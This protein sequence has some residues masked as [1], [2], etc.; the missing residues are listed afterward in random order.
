VLL[1]GALYV[2]LLAT[3]VGPLDSV[4]SIDQ[5]VRLEHIESLLATRF[6][7][8][9]TVYPGDPI[10]P[11]HDF[12]PLLNQY[13]YRDGRSYSMFSAAFSAL[14]SLPYRFFSYAGLYVVPIASTLGLLLIAG[15]L[16]RGL[17]PPRWR[18]VLI[19]ALSLTTPL[20]FYSLVFWDHTL[21]SML[22][23]LAL[24]WTIRADGGSR[25]GRLAGAGAVLGVAAWFRPEMVL[26]APSLA[27]ALLLA[28]VPPGWKL[29]VPLA[30]GAGAGLAPLFIFNQAA[31]GTFLGPHVLVAARVTYPSRSLSELLRARAD[32]AAFLISPPWRVGIAVIGVLLVLRFLGARVSVGAARRS[33]LLFSAAL[34]TGL[35]VIL[36][37]RSA[38]GLETTL[39]VTAPLTLLWLLPSSP[40]PPPASVDI[41]PGAEPAPSAEHVERILGVFGISYLALAFL[42]GLPNGGNQW[43]P[44]VLLPAVAP[45]VIAGFLRAAAWRLQRPP[46]VAGAAVGAAFLTLAAAGVASEL[47][48]LRT[49]EAKNAEIRQFSI[50]VA[51]TG[52]RVVVCSDT[53][54]PKLL[55]PIF[56]RGYLMFRAETPDR[57]ARFVPNLQ[58]NG[59]RRFV[60]IDRPEQPVLASWFASRGVVA[61]GPPVPLPKGYQLTVVRLPSPAVAPPAAD[62]PRL[63]DEGV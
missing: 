17:L 10:D 45:L 32:W 34:M 25:I 56:Y 13:L 42:A 61:E 44:R 40:E 15:R 27:L 62:S 5:G 16:T 43:G 55:A 54:V 28:K 47:R 6:H 37:S 35:G 24:H 11:K 31:Y 52:E 12:T 49:L 3:R 2:V 59:F 1:V 26:A 63:A 38:D 19:L 21:V 14:T 46:G 4:W 8:L 51:G 33:P 22:V 7:S 23:L 50:A 60:L 36:L 41:G 20:L 9:A 30:A 53:I 48:G 57:L 39:L 18:I 58:N 29:I